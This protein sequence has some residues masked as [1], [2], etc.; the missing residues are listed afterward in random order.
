M[1]PT[2]DLLGVGEGGARK[3][4][5]ARKLKTTFSIG[6]HTFIVN[7]VLAVFDYIICYCVLCAFFEETENNL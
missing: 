3:T 1:A 2:G 5:G 6:L 7:A 4:F